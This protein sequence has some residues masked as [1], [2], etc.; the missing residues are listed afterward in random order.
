[1]VAPHVDVT[2]GDAGIGGENEQHRMRVRNQVQRQFRL[3]ANRIQAWRIDD[4][5]PLLQQR[6]R[7]IYDRMT[8]LRNLDHAVLVDT[9]CK[10][11]V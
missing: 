10:I 3:G 5:Q 11:R 1:M 2:F 4:H 8:P 9:L 7:K 6:M